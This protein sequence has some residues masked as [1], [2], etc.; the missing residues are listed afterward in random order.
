MMSVVVVVPGEEKNEYRKDEGE[1]RSH[2]I[3]TRDDVSS[4]GVRVNPSFVSVHIVVSVCLPDDAFVHMA[5]SFVFLTMKSSR[6]M[7]G[8]N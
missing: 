2:F 3:R 7:K 6:S 4:S 1:C 8:R 5:V